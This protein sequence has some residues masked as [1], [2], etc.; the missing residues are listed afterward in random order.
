MG[1]A[2][3]KAWRWVWP[4]VCAELEALKA[5][6]N[7]PVWIMEQALGSRPL[8]GA[9]M[10]GTGICRSMMNS[11][12]ARSRPEWVESRHCAAISCVLRQIKTRADTLLRTMRRPQNLLKSLVELRGRLVKG[13]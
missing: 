12:P 2:W 11:H 5:A 9:Y 13:G 7:T 6:L 4:E 3:R 10:I 1:Y 8:F